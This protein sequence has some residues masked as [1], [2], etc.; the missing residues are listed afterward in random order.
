MLI[1]DSGPVARLRARGQSLWLDYIQRD[2]ILSGRLAQMVEAHLISGVTSNPSIFRNA[3]LASDAYDADL[4]AQSS[5][6]VTDPYLAFVAVGGEDIR[7]AALVLEHVHQSSGG[8]DGFVSFEVPPSLSEDH[9]ATIEEA[10][11]LQSLIARPN[12]MIKV[13]GN[14]AGTKA[15]EELI[16]EGC[17]V[18]QTLLFGLGQYEQSAMAYIR[19]L[20]R[21]KACGKPL[22]EV[23]S[24]AS[25]FV[26]RVDT[27]IDTLLPEDSDLR[28]MTA[29]ANACVIY[30]KFREIFS[31]SRWEALAASGAKVQ[32]LLWASTSTKNMAYSDT[33]YVD[34]LVAPGT[35]NTVP[36][37]TLAAFADHGDTGDGIENH[38][39]TADQVLAGVEAAGI[40]LTAV[41]DRLFAEGLASFAT[42]F[43]ALLAEIEGLLRTKAE[44]SSELGIGD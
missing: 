2:L 11:R 41:T 18:N 40:D 28:G 10:R 4:R 15:L 42:D 13:P 29:I 14:E 17:N 22:S 33:K 31:G 20:E 12:V 8:L 35:V 36:E 26:S 19:G 1:V 43:G 21:R 34:A 23:S 9:V 16:I 39:E 44:S 30:R 27:A 3:I 37:S 6:G 38:L 5:S 7:L 32:R 25:V 24:V